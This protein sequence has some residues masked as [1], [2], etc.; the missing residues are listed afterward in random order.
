MAWQLKFFFILIILRISYAFALPPDDAQHPVFHVL[1][2]DCE[3]SQIDFL[4]SVTVLCAKAKAGIQQN[5]NLS[6]PINN[7][8][9]RYSRAYLGFHYGTAISF[10][11]SRRLYV[12]QT[13]AGEL[14]TVDENVDGDFMFVRLGNPLRH[15]WRLNFGK[16]RL[17][18]GIDQSKLAEGIQ[19][20][21]NHFFTSRA[22][23]GGYFSYEDNSAN[24]I[25]FGLSA[26]SLAR[27][28]DPQ[29]SFLRP[30]KF[31]ESSDIVFRAAHDISALNG[32]RFVFSVLYNDF[33]FRRYGIAYVVSGFDRDL[34][35]FEFIRKTHQ[36][37][38]SR[39][40]QIFKLNYISNWTNQSRWIFEFEEESKRDR[41]G[42]VEYDQMIFNNLIFKTAVGVKNGQSS[43]NKSVFYLVSG[44]EAH[45]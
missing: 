3:S 15:R 8:W 22:A 21:K 4:D 31:K 7:F 12:A 18:F 9:L 43:S 5:F 19:I 1:K 32:S 34:F 27:K 44:L 24:L 28:N 6:Q 20:E 45:L 13:M 33:L 25:E 40:D 26:P 2:G 10:H 30:N 42:F 16:I 39:Y 38:N 14:K 41:S 17:P 36:K 11:I 37:I 29:I 35:Y 23:L